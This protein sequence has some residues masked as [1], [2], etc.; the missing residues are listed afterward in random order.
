MGCT[1]FCPNERRCAL[2]RRS[3]CDHRALPEGRLQRVVLTDIIALFTLGDVDNG[4]CEVPG[5]TELLH[6]FLHKWFDAAKNGDLDQF[7]EI[8]PIGDVEQILRSARQVHEAGRTMQS[9]DSSSVY[10]E[11]TEWIPTGKVSELYRS[12]LDA[13]SSTTASAMTHRR[14]SHQLVNMLSVLSDPHT[15]SSAP[16]GFM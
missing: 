11:E 6:A 4:F 9:R 5:D 1:K 2:C 14:E 15:A 3:D 16:L 12:S 7:G 10:T 8:D 13:T